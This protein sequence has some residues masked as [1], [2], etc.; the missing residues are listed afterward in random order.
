MLSNLYHESTITTLE[1][2][3]DYITIEKVKHNGRVNLEYNGFKNS[4]IGY[5]L[6]EAITDFIKLYERK[7]KDYEQFNI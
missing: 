4:Y 6:E 5:T 2:K 1:Y 7:V 3:D